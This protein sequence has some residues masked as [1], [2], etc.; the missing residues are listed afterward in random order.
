ME[1][2]DFRLI[3]QTDRPGVNSSFVVV[4][5][6]GT[7]IYKPAVGEHLLPDASPQFPSGPGGMAQ[8]EVAAF[9]IDRLFGFGRVPATGLV[10]GPFGPG[11]N[12]RFVAS[13]PPSFDESFDAIQMQ[14]TAVLDYIVAN[15]DRKEIRNYRITSSGS[16]VAIDN[17]MCF[18]H[19][20]SPDGVQSRFV[21]ELRGVLLA[22]EIRHRV[23][24]VRADD[25]R[26]ALR[27]LGL[28]DSA[29]EGTVERFEEI[30]RLG[31]VK[32]GSRWL[33]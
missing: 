13:R 28:H 18:P 5:S 17:G 25:I 29:V 2:Q 23:D 31:R 11:S 16:I 26:V 10:D 6:A 24:L 21:T 30:R 15:Q 1:E 22:P 20:P 33:P 14:Q 3:A 7:S 4:S 27:D 8:R 32:G 9:R 12:Q 19:L